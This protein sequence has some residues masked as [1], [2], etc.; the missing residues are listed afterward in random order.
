MA[1][2][3]LY[4]EEYC[5]LLVKHMSDGLS[6]ESFGAVVGHHKQTLY[7]WSRKHE[8]FGDAKKRGEELS[9][10]W[11]EKIGIEGL[12]T[13]SWTG[14]GSKALNATVWIFNMK[15][16]FG[17]R[18]KQKEEEIEDEARESQKGKAQLSREDLV[19]L[20]QAAKGGK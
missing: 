13:E 8:A 10:L 18:D 1:P 6:F 20:V 14:Q 15:N 19:F 12:W 16:R 9:R 7:E 2:P 3:T 4:K 17:W 5:E 11:W